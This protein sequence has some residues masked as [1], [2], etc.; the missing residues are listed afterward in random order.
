MFIH[1]VKPGAVFFSFPGGGAMKSFGQNEI[2]VNTIS[3]IL[4]D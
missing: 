2:A 3:V 1:T 4:N